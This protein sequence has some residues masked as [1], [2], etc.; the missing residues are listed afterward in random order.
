MANSNL[1][2]REDLK[3]VFEALGEGN[4]GTRI[5]VLESHDYI[6]EH[7][8]SGS[9]TYEKWN[10]GICKAWYFESFNVQPSFVQKATGIYSNDEWT[11]KTISLPDGLFTVV[12]YANANIMTNSYVHIGVPSYNSTAIA[13][14]VWMDLATSPKLTGLGIEAIGRWK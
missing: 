4:Y 1:V 14:R 3:N 9:W 10:S 7:S 6:V 5:D 13:V 2:T 8:T 11:T 12:T